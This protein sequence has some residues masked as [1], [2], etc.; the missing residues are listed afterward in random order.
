MP[1][2]WRLPLVAVAIFREVRKH[3]VKRRSVP[4]R[5]IPDHP[6][7]RGKHGSGKYGVGQIARIKALTGNGRSFHWLLS[8]VSGFKAPQLADAAIK[9]MYTYGV[10]FKVCASSDADGF[11]LC[12][13]CSCC[14]A[15][16]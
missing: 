8:K 10:K 3:S 16:S 6:D 15:R 11:A 12:A 1:Q 5:E 13:G 14:P 7:G 9:L 4:H 2:I